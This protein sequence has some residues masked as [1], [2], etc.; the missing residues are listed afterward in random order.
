MNIIQKKMLIL[1]GLIALRH[2]ITL[3]ISNDAKGLFGTVKKEYDSQYFV[4]VFF[5]CF[6]Y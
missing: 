2:C 3:K 5:H 4:V 1:F 6:M